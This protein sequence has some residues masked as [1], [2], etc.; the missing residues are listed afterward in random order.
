MASSDPTQASLTAANWKPFAGPTMLQQVPLRPSQYFVV[1]QDLYRDP[2]SLEY[3]NDYVYFATST[4][5]GISLAQAITGEVDEL[6]GKDIPAFEASV[7]SK[8]SVRIQFEGRRPYYRQVMALRSTMSAEPIGKGKLAQK[9]AEETKASLGGSQTLTI[10]DISVSFERV[11][12]RRL[13]RASKGSW[14]PDY[15]VLVD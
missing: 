6:H 13:R 3:S 15:Y 10:G 14:Q 9:I 1:P 4:A 7:S 11:F 5:H 12:L 8:I 2:N